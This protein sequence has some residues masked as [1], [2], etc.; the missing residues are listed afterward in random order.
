[1][2]IL[3]LYVDMLEELVVDTEVT[4]L[5][6]GAAYGVELVERVHSYALE[7]Y[8]ACLVT[9][10]ELAV[11]AKGCATCRKAKHEGW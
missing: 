7:G 3:G 10:H 4:A 1:M 9:L 6:L 11:E 8:L 5:L 2:H